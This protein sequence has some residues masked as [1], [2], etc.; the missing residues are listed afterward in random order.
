[1]ENGYT[2]KEISNK[3]NIGIETLRYYE[4]INIIPKPIRTESGY[5]IYSEDDLLRLKFIKRSKELGFS[6]GEIASILQILSR[7]KNIDNKKLNDLITPKIEEIDKKI[8]ELT[9]LKEIL[10]YTRN[11]KSLGKC[12]L[13]K[14]IYKST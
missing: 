5:R 14:F 3:L 9:R 4:N 2:R 12:G 1:M 7:D 10:D 11:D 8:T 13:F 6:L